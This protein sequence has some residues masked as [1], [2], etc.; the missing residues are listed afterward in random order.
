MMKN[1]SH[2][3][4]NGAIVDALDKRHRTPLHFADKRHRTPL[5]FSSHY[6][7]LDI[8]QILL[9]RGAVTDIPNMHVTPLHEASMA[10]RLKATRLLLQHGAIVHV[11][12]TLGQTPLHL[13]SLIGHHLLIRV[14][15]EHGADPEERDDDSACKVAPNHVRDSDSELKSEEDETSARHV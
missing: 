5:H 9:E 13:A 14:L 6:G 3:L 8:M 1:M 10:G 2:M 12:N 11:K 4:Q 15:L 7:Y